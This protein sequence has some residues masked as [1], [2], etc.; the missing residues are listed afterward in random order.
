MRLYAREKSPADAVRVCRR[1]FLGWVPGPR[2]RKDKTEALSYDAAGETEA[3][4]RKSKQIRDKNAQY[5]AFCNENNLTQRLER[6]QVV[7]YNKSVSSKANAAANRLDKENAAE[8]AAKAERQNYI[9]NIKHTLPNSNVT[10]SD[11]TL[12]KTLNVDVLTKGKYELHSVAP[13]DVELTDVRIIAGYGTSSNFRNAKGFAETYGGEAYK[14]Q[15]VG[16]L[17]ETDNYVYDVHWHQREGSNEHY[18]YELISVKE[19]KK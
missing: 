1:S 3:F 16:G 9:K 6:T 15:K 12:Q 18:V 10:L 8:A 14:W 2:I 13:K 11:T 19:K 17:I 5:K 7:G 4:K